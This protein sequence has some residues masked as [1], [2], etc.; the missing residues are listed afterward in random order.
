MKFRCSAAQNRVPRVEGAFNGGAPVP[1]QVEQMITFRVAR[2]LHGWSVQ[3]PHMT[4]P[5]RTRDVA[6]KEANALAQALRAHGQYTDVIID[7]DAPVR[8]ERG[9]IDVASAA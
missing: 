4:T 3:T 5:F 1:M 6:I 8:P 2:E 9:L 7:Q